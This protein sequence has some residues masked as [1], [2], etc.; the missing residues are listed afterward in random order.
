MN[1]TNTKTLEKARNGVVARPILSPGVHVP[2]QGGTSL[3]SAAYMD[4][5]R[6]AHRRMRRLVTRIIRS[7]VPEKATLVSVGFGHIRA[8]KQ[9]SRSRSQPGYDKLNKG[10]WKR[11]ES[12]KQDN[13]M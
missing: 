9:S 2:Y 3:F 7:N 4:E 8:R 13:Y 1:K 5:R 11:I 12:G 10:H 6:V